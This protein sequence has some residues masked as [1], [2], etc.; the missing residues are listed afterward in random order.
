MQKCG[1]SRC[2]CFQSHYLELNKKV[3]TP[4]F[5]TPSP[6]PSIKNNPRWKLG[7]L[8]PKNQVSAEI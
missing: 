6:I 1:K 8:S 5:E 4:E 7:I 3:S 2:M